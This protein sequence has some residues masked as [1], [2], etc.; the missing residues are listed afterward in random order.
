MYEIVLKKKQKVIKPESRSY[1]KISDTGGDD[2]GVKYGYVTK[3]AYEV[4]EW[5]E[6]FKQQTENCRL[7]DIVRAFNGVSFK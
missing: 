6:I 4:E 3:P 2:G 5:V 7:F 1:E